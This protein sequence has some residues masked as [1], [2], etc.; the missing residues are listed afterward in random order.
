MVPVSPVDFG[1][2]VRLDGHLK[3]FRNILEEGQPYV[4]IRQNS[5]GEHLVGYDLGGL[6]KAEISSITI[7]GLIVV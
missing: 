6:L 7:Y 2:S 5:C 4:W 1:T 3:R